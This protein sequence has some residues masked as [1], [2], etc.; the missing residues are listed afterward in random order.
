[1]ASSHS[2]SQSNSTSVVSE[3]LTPPAETVRSCTDRERRLTEYIRAHTGEDIAVWLTSHVPTACVTPTSEEALVESDNAEFS[4]EQA[5]QLAESVDADYLVLIGTHPANVDSLPISDQLTADRAQ[6][7]GYALHEL[8]HIRYT[9]IADAASLLEERVDEDWQE[10]VHGLW[11]SCEDAAIENQLA[12]DQ[13]Q[14]AADRLELVSRSISTHADDF[15]AN[16][17]CELTFRDAVDTA[18]S[19]EGIYDTGVRDAL[20]DPDD[21]RIVFASDADRQ[22]FEQ[23]ADSIAELVATVLRTPN[24]VERVEHILDWWETTI[25]P[26]LDPPEQNQQESGQPDPAGASGE[27]SASADSSTSS[28][29]SSEERGT[30]QSTSEGTDADRSRSGEEKQDKGAT[31]DSTSE[32][33]SFDSAGRDER[34]T[35]E[36]TNGVGEVDEADGI[37]EAAG[38]Q[39]E[40]RP[41]PDAINT[42]QRQSS[43]GADALDYPDIGENED[44][45]ALDQPESNDEG[46]S[47]SEAEGEE[48]TES[49]SPVE[50]S[51]DTQTTEN[52]RS[53]ES[54]LDAADDTP[55]ETATETTVS[56]AESGDEDTNGETA[57][58]VGGSDNDTGRDDKGDTDSATE[59]GTDAGSREETAGGSDEQSAPEHGSDTSYGDATNAADE[60]SEQGGEGEPES[61]TSESQSNENPWGTTN[62]KGTNQT[63]LGSFSTPDS[64]TESESGFSDGDKSDT[65]DIIPDTGNGS[66]NGE[67]TTESGDSDGNARDEGPIESSDGGSSIGGES[68]NREE[69]AEADICTGDESDSNTVDND[70]TEKRADTPSK[71]VSESDEPDESPSAP[72]PAHAGEEES[73]DREGALSA[74]HDAAHDEAERATPDEKALE[75][76]FEDIDNALDEQ[77]SGGATPGS[78][79][80]L[81]IMPDAGG[82][83]TPDTAERWG[84]AAADAEF[85]ADAL[86]KAL[87]ESRRDAHR[88]GVTS[89]TFDRQR[90]GALARGD[91]GAFH[92]RQPGDDKQ[93]DLVMILDRSDSMRKHIETAENA[94]VRFALACEDIGINV[95]VIDFYNDDVRLI[96]PFSVECGHVRKSFLSC[97]Y[98][99]NTPLADALGL[100]RELL[101]QRRNSPLVLIVTDGKPGDKDAYHDEISQSYA[102]VC[103]LTLVLDKPSGC[104][105]ERVAQNEQF[106]DRHV[107]VHEPDQLA[108]RL[109]QFA[110]M[111]DGL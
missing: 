80:E 95:G 98:D 71:S 15:A 35:D 36:A 63:S 83:P 16:E 1:M 49:Q 107:Y 54:A 70:E 111:V 106:Y 14:L 78:L 102:P 74:D 46:K 81:T 60:G 48:T 33:E 84:E 100:G 105:P 53:A 51:D 29:S 44:A 18:L 64:Q 6:Q 76:E 55:A 26:L 12:L 41:D 104:V 30:D 61:A 85:V 38:S 43:P 110:V 87:K 91:V 69:R 86:R 82:P 89:G 97:Q 8:G 68:K 34:D 25:K 62:S 73:L 13:S 59:N 22:A 93:Y 23:V 27:S 66:S 103:G 75:R 65:D 56:D 67:E 99:G 57:D 50:P 90:A 37:D 92:V 28:S 52:G 94:L 21:D 72:S 20:C 31:G 79:S 96:K 58:S 24:S 45:D 9:A 11:N 88:S 10:F 42:D 4:D 3:T 5:R 101:E 77:N 19:D 7:F 47:E 32:I 39:S 109:D 2:T 108:D 17:C 40:Q